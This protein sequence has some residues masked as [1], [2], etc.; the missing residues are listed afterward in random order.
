M[1]CLRAI[2][3]AQHTGQV[4]LSEENLEILNEELQQNF[5]ISADELQQVASD[6]ERV[7]IRL[8]EPPVKIKLVRVRK[9]Y[10]IQEK[11]LVAGQAL[12]LNRYDSESWNGLV[13]PYRLIEK[14]QEGLGSSPMQNIRASGAAPST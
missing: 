7:E 10:S 1:R 4:F 11:Q 6:K 3:E 2:G 5:R 13:E 9:Q 14:R 12:G 8:V